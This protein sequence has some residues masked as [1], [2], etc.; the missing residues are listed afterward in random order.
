MAFHQFRIIHF[1]ILAIIAL[2]IFLYTSYYAAGPVL[3]Q[4]RIHPLNNIIN[5]NRDL[6]NQ[7]K[8]SLVK[9][10]SK[11][12]DLHNEINNNLEVLNVENNANSLRKSEYLTKNEVVLD[13]SMYRKPEKIGIN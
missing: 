6:N 2:T 5:Q 4:R 9:P 13:R 8:Q 11:L 10:S 1:I 12:S 3:P 7:E